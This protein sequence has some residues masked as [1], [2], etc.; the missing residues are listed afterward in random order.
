M[1]STSNHSTTSDPD[2]LTES[3][4]ARVKERGRLRNVWLHDVAERLRLRRKA[5][6]KELGESLDVG[7]YPASVGDTTILHDHSLSLGKALGIAAMS[8]GLLAGGGGAGWILASK[9]LQPATTTIQKPASE[10]ADSKPQI[11]DSTVD[12]EIIPPPK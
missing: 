3:A 12:M 2:L 1:T 6:G 5:I 10:K 9:L 4:A 7:T 8:A 11:W